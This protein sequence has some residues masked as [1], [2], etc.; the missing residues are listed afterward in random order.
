M[1]ERL[2]ALETC[3]NH[4]ISDGNQ[5]EQ[6][7][8][9]IKHLTNEQDIIKQL[10]LS[11]FSQKELQECSR[12]GKRTNK[13]KDGNARP[14]LDKEKYIMLEKLSMAACKK[15]SQVEFKNK[16]ENI[17]KVLRRAPGPGNPE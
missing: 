16:F 10:T 7:T 13:C 3:S 6:L 17:Q 12:T 8:A 5:E 1:E 9:S 14:P 4:T 2:N 15:L 11:V